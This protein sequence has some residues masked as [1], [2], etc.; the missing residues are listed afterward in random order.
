M[1]RIE[2]TNLNRQF[3]FSLYKD[4]DLKLALPVTRADRPNTPL[5]R[6]QP[7]VRFRSAWANPDSF[8]PPQESQHSHRTAAH[9]IEYAHLIKWDEVHSGKGFDPDE[10]E[11]VQHSQDV[12]DPQDLGAGGPE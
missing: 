7:S 4:S 8:R 3:L 12:K 2:V 9:C 11:D 1:D 6:P 5:R 10:P